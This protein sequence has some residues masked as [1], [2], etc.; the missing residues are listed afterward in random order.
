MMALLGTA[1]AIA[2]CPWMDSG[3]SPTPSPV[4]TLDASS[5]R[6]AIASLVNSPT[7][8]PYF[9]P[10]QLVNDGVGIFSLGDSG[11]D[12]LPR[13]WGRTYLRSAQGAGNAFDP[14]ELRIMQFDNGEVS[15]D[16]TYSVVNPVRFVAD[17]AWLKRLV[18]KNYQERA[19]RLAHFFKSGGNWSLYALSPMVMAPATGSVVI[20]K[21]RLTSASPYASQPGDSSYQP[22]S[23][24]T[25]YGSLVAPYSDALVVKPGYRV[26]VEAQVRTSDPH[27][28]YV[29]LT[30]P[31][32][33]DRLALLDDGR[34]PDAVPNDGIYAASFV[35]PS[36]PGLNH[37]V[38]DAVAA[39][40]FEDLDED[41]YDA[42]LWGISYYISGGEAR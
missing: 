35:A 4:P 34:G 8:R 39:T 25:S 41:R 1:L 24:S 19:V 26:S 33:R 11:A 36:T 18:T 29:F 6:A 3:P 2:G 22:L 13:R 30:L 38:V 17:Y 32:G 10:G 20:R 16:A 12:G 14:M 37:I 31:P 40:T 28:C 27:G 5:E 7:V 9:E 21:V 15:A 23:E 42:A